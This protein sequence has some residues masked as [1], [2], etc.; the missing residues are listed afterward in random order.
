MNFW[1]SVAG[2]NLASHLSSYLRRKKR[3]EAFRFQTMDELDENLD[4]LLAQVYFFVT[5][6]EK[7]DGSLILIMER[8]L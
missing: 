4:R 6:I 8:I 1:E 5:I 2:H 7:K 3:Q